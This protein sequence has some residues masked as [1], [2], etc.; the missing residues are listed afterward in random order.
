LEFLDQIRGTA[1]FGAI[2][3]LI[4]VLI[5]LGRRAT[6]EKRDAQR[7]KTRAAAFQDYRNKENELAAKKAGELARLQARNEYSSWDL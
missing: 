4:A 5:N 3:F 2:I 7:Y 1:L 6:G